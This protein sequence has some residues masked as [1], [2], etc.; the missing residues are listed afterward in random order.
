MLDDNVLLALAAIWAV[1]VIARTARS[2]AM[3]DADRHAGWMVAAAAVLALAAVLAVLQVEGG[4]WIA[5]AAAALLLVIPLWL[6]RW[7]FWLLLGQRYRLANAVTTLLLLLHP[8]R[9]LLAD[10][11]VLAAL[12]RAAAGDVPGAL[13]RFNAVAGN[14][15]LPEPLRLSALAWAGR[16]RRDWPDVIALPDGAVTRAMRLRGFGELGQ[17]EA[18]VANYLRPGRDTSPLER[19]M[20]LAFCGRAA[21]VERLIEGPLAAFR[22]DTQAFWRATARLAA[23]DA[24]AAETLLRRT[25]PRDVE[26]R[27]SFTDRLSHGLPAPTLSSA[28]RA[29]VDALAAQVMAAPLVRAR[30]PWATYA[31]IALNF[32]VFA[33][34]EL[35]GGSTD[36]DTLYTLGALSPEAVVDGGE[37][38]RIGAALFLHD[39]Y[40]HVLFNM[41][42]LAVFGA[43]LERELGHLRFVLVYLGAGLLSMASVLALTEAG[44]VEPALLVGASGAIMG[45]VGASAGVAARTL[46]SDPATSRQTLRSAALIVA[47]QSVF[48]WTIP[49]VSFTGHIAG[50]MAGFLLALAL[51]PRR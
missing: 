13:A 45:L 39:G 28:S 6:A 12:R 5:L 41:A 10:R 44:L 1:L 48:D 18:L 37:Y 43:R 15:R 9:A 29:V 38:W 24:H 20:V 25:A 14:Q 50:A 49:H 16:V 46:R 33:I 19:L 17:T 35:A 27:A 23:G 3:R 42:A 21:A 30:R 26:M 47:M 2:P 7:Y 11:A 22:V 31:L 34:E 36:N 4:G 8:S 51:P 40:A 32:V